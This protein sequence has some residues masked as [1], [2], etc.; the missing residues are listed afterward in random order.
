MEYLTPTE[1]SLWEIIAYEIKVDIHRHFCN[2]AL[3]LNYWYAMIEDFT[4]CLSKVKR[5][6][7]S[8]YLYN[9]IGN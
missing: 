2:Y 8:Y 6:Y 9:S 4:K 5:L 3:P 7:I 1:S